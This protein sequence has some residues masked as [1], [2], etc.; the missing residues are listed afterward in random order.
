MKQGLL[1]ISFCSYKA[2]HWMRQMLKTYNPWS[3][4]KNHPGWFIGTD[5]KSTWASRIGWIWYKEID[6]LFQMVLTGLKPLDEQQHINKHFSQLTSERINHPPIF[7][8]LFQQS[9]CHSW[10]V[11]EKI[12]DASNEAANSAAWLQVINRAVPV[13][14]RFRGIVHGCDEF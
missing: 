10:L 8:N 12:S 3:V 13:G 11:Q 7:S 5:S 14:P 2:E 9:P 6:S 4:L 1:R